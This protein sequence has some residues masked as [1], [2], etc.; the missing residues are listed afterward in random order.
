MIPIRDINPTQRFAVVTAVLIVINCAVFLYELV[1]GPAAESFVAAFALVP[2]N[3]FSSAA[4]PLVPAGATVITSMFLHG[5]ILHVAGNML[6]LWIFGNN[7]EDAMGRIRFIVFYLI[8]GSIAAY[9]HAWLNSTSAVPMIGASGAVS[10]V[11]GAYLMLYPR[12]RVQTLV[13]F[14][15]LIRTVEIPAMFVLGFWFILQF[16]NALVSGGGGQGVAWFAHVGGFAAGIMLIGPFKR[17]DVPFG[18]RKRD[19]DL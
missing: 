8:C 1:L 13:I 7:I 11:L 12:A 5:G 19:Y 17:R 2:K 6:Y 10:G 4:H 15:F 16:L 3:L 14:G 18:G 9:A